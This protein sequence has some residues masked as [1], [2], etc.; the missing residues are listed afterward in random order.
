MKIFKQKKI[1]KVPEPKKSSQDRVEKILEVELEVAGKIAL[2]KEEAK[3][4]IKY[5]QREPQTLKKRAVI[6][7]KKARDE[8]IQEGIEDAHL[9]AQKMILKAE[10]ESKEIKQKGMKFIDEA[11]KRMVS[12]VLGQEEKL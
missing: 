9:K 4:K 10:E 8:M 1:K 6:N 3:E 11:E 5:A 7:G 2:A 12:F